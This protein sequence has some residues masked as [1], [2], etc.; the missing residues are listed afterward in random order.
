MP[1]GKRSAN[2]ID[3][4]K[5]EGPFLYPSTTRLRLRE[6]AVTDLL[7]VDLLHKE[8]VVLF[9]HWGR[10]DHEVPPSTVAGHGGVPWHGQT[11]EGPNVRIIGE[12]CEKL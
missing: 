1:E 10:G 3:L 6:K 12:G 7:G 4:G 9:V 2:Q 11:H 5:E 8:P